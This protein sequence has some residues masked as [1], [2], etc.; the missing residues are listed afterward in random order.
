MIGYK[1][2]ALLS[3]FSLSD[4]E[5]LTGNK[6]T[7]YSLLYRLMQKGFVKKIKSSLYT[8]VNVATDEV[9]ASKYQIACGSNSTAYLSHHTAFE[10]Y[11][12]ANQ[13]YFDIYVSSEKRFRDFEFE[14]LNF[15]Y[16]ASKLSD[17]VVK[18]KN[19]E[20]IR[21]TDLER[22]VVDS[23]KDFEKIA[24]IEELLNCLSLIYYLDAEKLKTY[25]DG[26]NVQAVYQKAG[27]ILEH[28]MHQMQLPESF[29]GYCKSRIGKSTRYLSKDL[30]YKG[31]YNKEWKLVVSERIFDITEQG[32][33]E[34][35]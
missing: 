9:I 27:F 7:A 10:Y 22:T 23:I 19:T 4:V 15:K 12:L 26:Y 3:V 32:G 17:G 31:I 30:M 14:G 21:V 25:L 33:G 1:E 13:V 5:N 2:L 8:C 16:I 35:V 28:Y 11:G 24:G 34:L 29:I 6:K 18:P 20:G